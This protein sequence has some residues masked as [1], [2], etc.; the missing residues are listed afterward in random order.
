MARSVDEINFGPLTATGSNR[1]VP[2]YTMTIEAKWTR[3]DGTK[4][5][6]S[7]AVT[8]PG[9]LS[10]MP[11]HVRQ[12]YMREMMIHT[13]RVLAGIEEWPEE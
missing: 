10:N 11:L 6:N 7:R 3:D 2:E 9:L 8:F 5:Q 12:E 1:Q 4:A 13:V